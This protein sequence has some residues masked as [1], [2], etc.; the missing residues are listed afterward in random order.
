LVPETDAMTELL[1]ALGV[2]EEAILPED[3]SRN[4]YENALYVRELLAQ[5]DS[6][7]I[8]LVTSALHMPRSV[9][10]FER[11]GFSVTPAPVD[12]FVTEGVPG[13]TTDSGWVGNL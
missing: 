9:A 6:N 7:E 12:Y 8:V 1:V 3:R 10:I 11:Q 5:A 2:P 13:L 4:T